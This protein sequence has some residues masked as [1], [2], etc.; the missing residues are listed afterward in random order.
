MATDSAT[1]CVCVCVC[2]CPVREKKTLVK[3]LETENASVNRPL[4]WIFMGNLVCFLI[5]FQLLR[6][7]VNVIN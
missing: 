6:S 1:V 4:C 2:V 7:T 3:F 5:L